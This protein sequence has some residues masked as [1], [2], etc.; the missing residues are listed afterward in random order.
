ME[1]EAIDLVDEQGSNTALAA[2]GTATLITITVPPNARFELDSFA[3]Y[4]GEVTAFGTCTWKYKINGVPRYPL[5]N[6]KDQIGEQGNPRQ[7]FAADLGARG[8]DVVT[9][10]VTNADSVSHSVG[11][12]I[13]GR[14]AR[15][16]KATQ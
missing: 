14:F 3:T 10:D 1:T 9:L 15:R 2:G 16:G 11:G 6:I 4:A 12:I 5:N 8:G 13:R 7:I